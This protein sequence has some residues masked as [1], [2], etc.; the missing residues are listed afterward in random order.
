M[1]FP[2]QHPKSG[3]H[4]LNRQFVIGLQAV[5]FLVCYV[6]IIV[7]VIKQIVACSLKQGKRLK[8]IGERFTKKSQWVPTKFIY[9][10]RYECG[11]ITY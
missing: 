11:V 10:N 8:V 1:E 4:T 5:H 6:F 7:N 2:R 3:Q 9:W